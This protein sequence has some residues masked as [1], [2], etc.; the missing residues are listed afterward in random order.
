MQWILLILLINNF[1]RHCDDS[2][3]VHN[4]IILPDKLE[5]LFK[6]YITT[7]TWLATKVRYGQ[8]KKSFFGGGWRIKV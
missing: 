5:E 7:A 2:F 8:V 4:F 1:W 6:L 3:M